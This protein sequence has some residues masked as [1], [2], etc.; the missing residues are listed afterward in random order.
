MARFDWLDFLTAWEHRNLTCLALVPALRHI[1]FYIYLYIFLCRNIC[2]HIEIY[3]KYRHIE[4]YICIFLNKEKCHFTHTGLL[5]SKVCMY[6]PSNMSFRRSGLPRL[7]PQ[8]TKGWP[9][10]LSGPPCPHL[11][12]W[13]TEA[14][15]SPQVNIWPCSTYHHQGG[16]PTA[17]VPTPTQPP[18]AKDPI[19]Y[20]FLGPGGSH[21]PNR[22]ACSRASSL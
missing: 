6:S 9:W 5:Q 14:S 17:I 12:T 3:I 11:P 7:N 19:Q 4:K 10:L 1:Y 16:A 13:Y 20:H 18:H 21:I 8:P 15:P 2:L 22:L